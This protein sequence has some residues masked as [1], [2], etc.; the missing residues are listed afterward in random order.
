MATRGAG[1][2]LR[3]IPGF[4]EAMTAQN[5]SGIGSFQRFL[6]LFSG[7]FEMDGRAPNVTVKVK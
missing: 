5:I 3:K 4:A 6:N 7:E 2:K 1:I